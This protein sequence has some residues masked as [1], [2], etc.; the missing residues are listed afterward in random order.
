[1]VVILGGGGRV[2]GDFAGAAA[3]NNAVRGPIAESR[4]DRVEITESIELLA[5]LVVAGRGGGGGD[6]VAGGGG[7]ALKSLV[8]SV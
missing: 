8:V 1:V 7:A 6:F 3:V 5:V 2:G 4:F